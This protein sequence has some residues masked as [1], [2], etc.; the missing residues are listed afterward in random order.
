MIHLGILF[1]ASES[2][3]PEL[4]GLAHDWWG[5]GTW[6]IIAIVAIILGF[7]YIDHRKIKSAVTGLSKTTHAIKEEVTNDHETNLRA[8]V[9]ETRDEAAAGKRAAAGAKSVAETVL[10]RVEDVLL[11]VTDLAEVQRQQGTQ[12]GGL[13]TDLSADREQSRRDIARLDDDID[14]LRRKMT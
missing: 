11:R 13:R 5:I 14:E 1:I 2:L 4:P 6:A 12:L 8:D 9:D 3:I 7:I 10:A